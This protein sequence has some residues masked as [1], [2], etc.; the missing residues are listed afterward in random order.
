MLGNSYAVFQLLGRKLPEDL[1][2]KERPTITARLLGEKQGLVWQTWLD[3]ERKRT[4][5]EIYREP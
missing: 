1:M 3:E 4:E 2:E 5:I